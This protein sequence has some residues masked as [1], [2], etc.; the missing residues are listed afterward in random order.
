MIVES[1]DVGIGSS[2]H[3]TRQVIFGRPW[4]CAERCSRMFGRGCSS[5]ASAKC[6]VVERFNVGEQRRAAYQVAQD[7]RAVAKRV[8]KTAGDQPVR[9]G[10]RPLRCRILIQLISQ[11]GHFRPTPRAVRC[12]KYS[13]AGRAGQLRRL[14]TSTGVRPECTWGGLV[15]AAHPSAVKASRGASYIRNPRAFIEILPRKSEEPS[16]PTKS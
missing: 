15:Q 2:H 7:D 10:K 12:L 4:I 8:A 1:N 16:Q 3:P 14:E 9:F 5:A 11:M 6:T 13:R